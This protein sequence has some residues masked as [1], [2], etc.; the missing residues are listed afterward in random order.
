[1]SDK[2]TEFTAPDSNIEPIGA[3]NRSS[4]VPEADSSPCENRSDPPRNA[5]KN[6]IKP[7]SVRSLTRAAL[8]LAAALILSWL[9]AILPFQIPIPGVKLGFSNIP[10]ILALYYAPFGA[11]LGFGILKAVLTS[12]FLGKFSGLLFALC[13]TVCS[14]CAMAMIR[15]CRFLSSLSVCVGGAAAHAV[16]QIAAACVLLS[17]AVISYLPIACA[18]SAACGGIMRILIAPFLPNAA[19]KRGIRFDRF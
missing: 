8:L 13:G 3:P 9:E 1:M 19:K 18:A 5:A 15:K 6:G 12:V 4:P 14:V 10:V 7:F 11:A 16:G 2:Q 17:P